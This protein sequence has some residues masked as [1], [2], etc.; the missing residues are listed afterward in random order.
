MTC[1]LLVAYY[2]WQQHKK[3]LQTHMLRVPQFCLPIQH[4]FTSAH[5][6]SDSNTGQ[7]FQAAVLTS[8][9]LLPA[10]IAFLLLLRFGNC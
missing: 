4:I 5:Q 7:C 9:L 1:A 3:V 10:L 6:P 2:W 8:C